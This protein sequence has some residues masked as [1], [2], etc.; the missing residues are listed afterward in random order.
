MQKKD[1]WQIPRRAWAKSSD[2]L[3]MNT[4]GRRQTDLKPADLKLLPLVVFGE[5]ETGGSQAMPSGRIPIRGGSP[6]SIYLVF[7]MKGKWNYKRNSRGHPPPN[8]G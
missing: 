7:P 5:K 4:S 6:D 3:A 1:T 8:P 2:F